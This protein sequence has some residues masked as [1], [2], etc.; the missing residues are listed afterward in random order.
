M[1]K[2]RNEIIKEKDYAIIK[3]NNNQ[4]GFLDCLI[5]TE[6]IEKVKDYYWNVRIDKRHNSTVYVESFKR[7][8]NKHTRI[9]LHRLL[10]D[11][12]QGYVIDHIN[13]NGLD[14]RK[15]NLRIITQ[16]QNCLNRRCKHYS[17]N[18]RDKYY[19][20][21]YKKK[22]IA[23]FKTEQEALNYSKYIDDLIQNGHWEV[24]KNLKTICLSNR[25]KPTM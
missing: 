5:D 7:I 17:Y 19:A 11:C 10:V 16:S 1:T 8:N 22:T 20:V 24:L 3:I 23:R 13:H 14:N 2:L 9:H 25:K 21:Y 18:K 12:T 6:D 15:Q 4:L